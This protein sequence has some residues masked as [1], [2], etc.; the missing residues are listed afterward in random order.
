MVAGN[1]D[2]AQCAGRTGKSIAVRKGAGLDG[3]PTRRTRYRASSASTGTGFFPPVD[4]TE[5][6]R[7]LQPTPFMQQLETHRR[8]GMRYGL[9]GRKV[10][11]CI[12]SKWVKKFGCSNANKMAAG[13]EKTRE[14]GYVHTEK[15]L[16]FCYLTSDENSITLA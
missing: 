16:W 9:Q 1:A 15:G 11:S 4:I 3:R 7:C 8:H 5:E 13:S 12:G 2:A 10:W 6:E 14:R